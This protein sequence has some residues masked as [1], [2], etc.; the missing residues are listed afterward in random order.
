MKKYFFALLSIFSVSVSA[1]VFTCNTEK[2]SIQIYQLDKNTYEYK[3]WNKPKL[4]TENPDMYVKDN[5]V[6]TIDGT[7]ECRTTNYTFKKGNVR[8]EIDNNANCVE[9]KPPKN[10]IG[11]LNVYIK[12]ELKSHHWC[13]K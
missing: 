6:I 7:K 4:I 12:D 9:G 10:A 5:D 8:F 11:N 1:Q 13:L 3:S 2:H